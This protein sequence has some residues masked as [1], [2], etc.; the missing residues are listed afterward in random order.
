MSSLASADPPVICT[1]CCLPVPRSLADTFTMPLASMSK[2]TSTCGTPRGAGA[3]PASSNMPSF[4]LYAAIS[5]SPWKTWICTEGWLSSAVVKIS[6]RLVGIV[7]FRSIS[8][9]KMPPLVSMPSD[10]GVTSSSRTSFTSPLSTPACRQAP[11]ATTS[12][13]LTPLF[14]SLPPVRSLTRSTTA[15]IRVEPPERHLVLGQVGAV[16]VLEVLDQPVHDPLV[17][18]VAA[19]VV[20]AA[21]RLDL[22]DALADLK[23]RDVERAAAQVEDQ[24]RGLRRLVQV[25]GQSGRRRLVDDPQHVQAGD[26][27]GLLGGLPLGVVEVGRHGDDRVGHRLA[28]VG[29]GVPLQLLQDERADLL[30]G[31]LLVVDLDGPVG[32]HLALHRTD[33]PVDVGHRLA[34]GDLADQH[35]AVLGERD[36][37]R[38]GPR[39]FRVRD[40]RGLAALENRNDGVGRPEIYAYRSCHVSVLVCRWPWSCSEP[41]WLAGLAE[42]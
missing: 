37:G 12:S 8:L 39:A 25:V 13:G 33:R 34:L 4:L 31:E 40:D 9:V 20:V 35:L 19:E 10:S 15:G 29:L 32:A 6:E 27:P 16:A 14:G 2:V 38:R 22:D 21:G 18:V 11:T 17:P 30:R 3:M 24:D 26:L 23:Q 41:S 42:A 5:R 1:D 7:V 36:D 28:Q